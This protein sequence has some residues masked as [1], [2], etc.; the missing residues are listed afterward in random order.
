MMCRPSDFEEIFSQGSRYSCSI[1]TIWIKPNPN[2]PTK[3]GFSVNR[4]IGNSVNRNLVRR[5][6]RESLR[7]L[8]PDQGWTLF[9]SAK[10]I[11]VKRTFNQIL[12][13]LKNILFSHG[14]SL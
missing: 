3:I 8:M 5:R 14:V 2:V 9:I 7:K 1:M 6:L 13:D 11:I 4:K 12:S 10:P